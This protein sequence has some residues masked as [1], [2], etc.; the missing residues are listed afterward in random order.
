MHYAPSGSWTTSTFDRMWGPS[1]TLPL[2][3]S[4]LA[5]LQVAALLD[6]ASFRD[7]LTTC[8]I[9]VEK[10]F[11]DRSWSSLLLWKPCPRISVRQGFPAGMRHRGASHL[12]S[13]TAFFRSNPPDAL[14]TPSS[15]ELCLL[16]LRKQRPLGSYISTLH[17]IVVHPLKKTSK[18]LLLSAPSRTRSLASPRSTALFYLS[19]PSSKLGVATLELATWDSA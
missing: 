4:A 10:T 8:L 2:A 16:N 13:A 1:L 6:N 9:L 18:A 3:S 19:L 11:R 7:G 17:R 12:P 5:R 14:L 15:N